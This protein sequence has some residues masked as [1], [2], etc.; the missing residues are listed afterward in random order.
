M[1]ENDKILWN[2]IF[3][4]KD[5]FSQMQN[6]FY[7]LTDQKKKSIQ[8]SFRKDAYSGVFLEMDTATYP[9]FYDWYYINM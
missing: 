1:G 8:K 2:K 6:R 9:I 3:L 7:L 4:I 5:E